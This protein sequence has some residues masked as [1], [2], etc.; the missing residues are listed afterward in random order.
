MQIVVVFFCKQWQEKRKEK[1]NAT[2]PAV[3]RCL[4]AARGEARGA[5]FGGF[6]AQQIVN[7]IPS[8]TYLKSVL[9]THNKTKQQTNK[10]PCE[11]EYM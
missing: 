7:R 4:P 9:N 2:P 3:N 8:G 5:G 6:G 11:K 10:P 1:P